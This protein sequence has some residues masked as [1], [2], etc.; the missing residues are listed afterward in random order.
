[1]TTVHVRAPESHGDVFDSIGRRA[2][3]DSLRE[4]GDLVVWT[5]SS[6]P[7]HVSGLGLQS[8]DT[9]TGSY[10]RWFTT[11]FVAAARGRA[12]IAVDPYQRSSLHTWSLVSLVLLARAR[13]SRALISGFGESTAVAD[14]T[15]GAFG[16]RL[17]DSAVSESQWSFRLGTS[18]SEWIAS[19]PYAALALRGDRP[20]PSPAWIEWF[21]ATTSTLGLTPAVVVHASEDYLSAQSLSHSLPGTYQAFFVSDHA[22]HERALREVYA[23]SALLVSDRPSALILGATEGAVPIGWVESSIGEI[24]ATF[25]ALAMPWVGRWEGDAAERLPAIDDATLAESA[26]RLAAVVHRERVRLGRSDRAGVAT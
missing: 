4:Y 21:E 17:V 14:A 5:G 3:L 16:D 12:R 9:A 8:S 19:R 6:S 26:A 18:V 23:R 1:M 24:G 25:D 10:R 20:P 15:F 13:R 7:Q 2:Y 22:D 11:A